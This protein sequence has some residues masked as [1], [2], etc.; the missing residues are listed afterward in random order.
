M[1]MTYHIEKPIITSTEEDMLSP[2]YQQEY[3]KTTELMHQTH[4]SEL[5][6]MNYN[7]FHFLQCLLGVI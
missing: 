4:L 1:E 6:T 5:L 7:S 2:K 3:A